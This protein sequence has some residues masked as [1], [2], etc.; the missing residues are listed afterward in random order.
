MIAYIDPTSGGL[1]IQLLLAGVAG[2]AVVVKIYFRKIR[3]FFSFSK[4]DPDKP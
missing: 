2:I 3:S 1:L 4:K